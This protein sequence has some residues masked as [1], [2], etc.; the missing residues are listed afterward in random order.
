MGDLAVALLTAFGVVFVAE[1]ADKTQLLA[2]SFGARVR[3]PVVA[4]GLL[5]GYGAANALAAVV[6]AIGGAQLPERALEVAGGLL[7]LAFAMFTLRRSNEADDVEPAVSVTGRIVPSIAVSIAVA[8]FG[9]KT[10]LATATLA[11]QSAAVAVWVGATLGATASGLL[12][13]LLGRAAGDR[14]PARS[15]AVASAML[16]AVFG[17]AMLAGWL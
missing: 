10:Q 1:L 8:E 6:G 16:F 2:L 13:A 17:V 4:V 5:L 9:D 14:L 15:I 3:L 12:G 11:A 7:F